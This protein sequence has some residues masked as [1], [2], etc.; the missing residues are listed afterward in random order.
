[1]F[2]EDYFFATRIISENYFFA[3]CN[4]YPI[5]LYRV[6]ECIYLEI[7][8]KN[9]MLGKYGAIPELKYFDISGRE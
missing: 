7:L 2:Y 9:Y 1:M 4:F 6:R 5:F 3:K 8:T